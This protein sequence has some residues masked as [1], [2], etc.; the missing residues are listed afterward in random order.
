[1]VSSFSVFCINIHRLKLGEI[2][3]PPAPPSLMGSAHL[4]RG[5]VQ[6]KNIVLVWET[7]LFSPKKWG[8]LGSSL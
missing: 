3:M 7:R 1:M 4:H 2:G 6:L 8:P 5:W